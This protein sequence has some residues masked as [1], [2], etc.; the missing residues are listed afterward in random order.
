MT[1]A[2]TVTARDMCDSKDSTG[3]PVYTI[4]EIAETLGVSRATIYDHL[5]PANTVAK[6][7]PA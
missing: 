4:S 6:A 7:E 2:M 1:P 3:R 5:A